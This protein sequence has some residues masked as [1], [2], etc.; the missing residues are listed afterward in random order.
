MAAAARLFVVAAELFPRPGALPLRPLGEHQP[1]HDLLLQ[2]AQL[3]LQDRAD[4]EAQPF[5]HLQQTEVA[6]KQRRP[7]PH[8]SARPATAAETPPPPLG[9][10]P[11]LGSGAPRRTRTNPL[12]GERFV[13]IRNANC[14]DDDNYATHKHAKVKAW[15]AQRPRYQVHYT[16]TY[17]SWLNQVE[18]WFGIISRWAIKRG[19]FRNVKELVQRIKEFTERYNRGARP[20]V[21][22]A[23]AQSIID[24]VARLSTLIC[25]TA[26]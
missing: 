8:H 15:L 20:F 13:P 12:L 4:V 17:A 11:A 14:S 6:G 3:L 22:T 19:S 23:T 26:H 5:G 7:Q 10:Q 24:K 1:A 16:P 18:I 21:W 2:M 25:G 9:A